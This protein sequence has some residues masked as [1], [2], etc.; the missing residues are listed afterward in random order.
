MKN[1]LEKILSDPIN[2]G[3]FR[4]WIIIIPITWIVFYINSGINYPNYSC[5]G[6][7]VESCSCIYTLGD[8]KITSGGSCNIF[9]KIDIMYKC[10]GFSLSDDYSLF[11]NPNFKD[12]KSC[13][14]FYKNAKKTTLCKKNQGLVES[15]VSEKKD[16]QK[17]FIINMILLIIFPLTF[18]PIYLGLRRT[19]IWVKEGFK[20]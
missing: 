1:Y 4:I 17:E 6:Q 9:S 15:C 10:S 11:K 2:K 8:K 13:S 18:Y 3:I 12:R 20:K 16:K 19:L 14:N 7:R 5:D